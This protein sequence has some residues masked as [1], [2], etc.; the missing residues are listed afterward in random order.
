MKISIKILLLYLSL[1]IAGCKSEEIVNPEDVYEEYTVVQAELHP[2]EPFPAVRF[3]K[4]LPLG[5]AYDIKKA[6]LKNV[7]VY[8][9]KNGIQVIPL[10][11]SYDGLYKPKYDFN[12]LEG[13]TYELFAETDDKYIYAKTLIPF[14]PRITS[15]KL[16]QDDFHLDA[17]VSVNENE[18]YGAVWII[19]GTPPLKAEDFYSISNSTYKQD[20]RIIVRT[21]PIPAEYRTPQYLA[22]TYIKVYAFDVAFREYFLSRNSGQEV[23]DPFV[24]GGGVIDWNVQGDKVIGMF[25]GVTPGNTIKVE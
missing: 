21:S 15:T 3:T 7:R 9:K 17:N 23:S 13:E 8:I 18:V 6:E 24:Q 19:S 2:D 11:Y 25:I 14:S 4:T 20:T 16:N 10:L 12:V 22:N 1:I 5:E